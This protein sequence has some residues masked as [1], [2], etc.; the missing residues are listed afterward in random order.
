[1]FLLSQLL[2]Y[3]SPLFNYMW[4]IKLKS[5]IFS[6]SL[7]HFETKT[8]FLIWDFLT[9]SLDSADQG[10]PFPSPSVICRG[11]SNGRLCRRQMTRFGQS[12]R[13]RFP[14]AHFSSLLRALYARQSGERRGALEPG[15]WGFGVKNQTGQ[16]EEVLS[17]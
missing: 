16:V 13:H 4:Y 10:I 8:H 5:H 2:R 14:I 17:A 11:N 3:D 7:K 6:F 9:R 12:R 1:M 15:N